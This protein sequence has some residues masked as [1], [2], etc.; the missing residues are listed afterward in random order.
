MRLRE[1]QPSSIPWWQDCWFW[2]MIIDG[3]LESLLCLCITPANE[4]HEYH[5]SISWWISKWGWFYPCNI[6]AKKQLEYHCLIPSKAITHYY[7]LKPN[8]V[9]LVQVQGCTAN[10]YACSVV[11]I[12]YC[13]W[14]PLLLFHPIIIQKINSCCKCW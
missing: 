11:T 12:Y 6:P 14:N 4:Q 8:A 1:S 10:K 13:F 5:Q 2:H 7:M 9:V 3:I